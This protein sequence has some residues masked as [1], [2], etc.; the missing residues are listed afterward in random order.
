MPRKQAAPSA[1][2]VPRAHVEIYRKVVPQMGQLT[3]DVGELSKKSPDT[4]M[5]KFKL[6]VIN[7]QLALANKLLQPPFKPMEGFDQF[8]DHTLP[9]N[10][11]VLIAL[12]QYLKCLSMWHAANTYD[13]FNGN[14]L[15]RT[16]GRY[17]NVEG[18]PERA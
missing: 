14:H 6:K 2:K 5:S 8:D 1:T 7:E 17:W 12:S 18:E 13:K 11:D 3:H 10:S 15:D 9:S 16:N 4:A